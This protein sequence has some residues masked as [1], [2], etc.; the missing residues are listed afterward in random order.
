MM[1]W[2]GLGCDGL[3]T[4]WFYL[5]FSV[6]TWFFLALFPI[7][8]VRNL[9]RDGNASWPFYASTFLSFA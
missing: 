8:M 4:D 6:F 5:A 3:L 9:E 1:W 7:L 2:D